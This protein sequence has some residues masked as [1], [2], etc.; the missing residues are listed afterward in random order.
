M[1]FALFPLV[2]LP[3]LLSQLARRTVVTGMFAPTAFLSLSQA[4]TLTPMIWTWP[5][6]APALWASHLPVI[7]KL[8]GAAVL[9]LPLALVGQTLYFL[10]K[11]SLRPHPFVEVSA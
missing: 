10:R 7:F 9:V 1:Q 4:W 6:A 5:A 8:A 3:T 11:L 2:T